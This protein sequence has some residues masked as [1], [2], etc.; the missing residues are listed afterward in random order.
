M[1]ARESLEPLLRSNSHDSA[2]EDDRPRHTRRASLDSI[3]ERME[4][5]VRSLEL[6][7]EGRDRIG[8]GILLVSC[9]LLCKAGQLSNT[10][11]RLE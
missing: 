11:S 10:N 1:N 6:A 2:G 3:D 7:T 4:I 9:T 5:R 8:G